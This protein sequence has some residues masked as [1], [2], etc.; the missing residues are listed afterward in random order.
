MVILRSDARV[1]A[2]GLNMQTVQ[3]TSVTHNTHSCFVKPM[4][5]FR[6]LGDITDNV[7]PFFSFP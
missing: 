2:G 3:G 5:Y 7:L 1:D 4:L 6:C